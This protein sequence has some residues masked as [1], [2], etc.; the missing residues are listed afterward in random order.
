MG[1]RSILLIAAILIGS[2]E[3]STSVPVHGRVATKFAQLG[4]DTTA[5]A[6]QGDLRI[7]DTIHASTLQPIER[8]DP[9]ALH[10]GADTV[11]FIRSTTFPPSSV[12]PDQVGPGQSTSEGMRLDV[13]ALARDSGQGDPHFRR[14]NYSSCPIDLNLFRTPARR[15]RAVWVSRA[16]RDTLACPRF[17]TGDGT[18]FETVW[19]VRGILGDSLKPAIYYFTIALHLADGRVLKSMSDSAYLTADPSPPAHDLSAVRFRASTTVGGLGPRMLQTKVVATNISRGLVELDY[20][21][22]ALSIDLFAISNPTGAPVW[23]STRRGPRRRPLVNP[24]GYACTA[25]LRTRILAPADSDVFETNIPLAEILADSLEF[26][27]Y[28]VEASLVLLNRELRPP[29]WSTDTTFR[30]GE[31]TIAPIADSM[32]RTRM[33]GGLRYTAASRLI[34]GESGADTVRTMVL[35]TNPSSRAITE[36]FWR[37][38][39]VTAAYGYRTA[40]DRD[41]LPLVRAAWEASTEC[42]VRFHWLEVK[43]R[44]HLLLYI[45]KPIHRGGGEIPSGRYYILAWS[46]GKSQVLLNAG[47][48]DVDR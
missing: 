14:L 35:V 23:R 40:A 17:Q 33:S 5:Y 24:G 12:R 47:T 15:G 46:G 7:L 11:V 34:R 48:V 3:A 16:A 42:P 44:Q 1:A 27:R 37:G 29:E 8:S 9:A 38:C 32:P 25:E 45:D 43:P 10:L 26:G 22:C 4:S 28:R 41:S 13:N 39:P 6:D 30:L 19:P 31:V 36:Q 21:S 20:G 2:L 18:Y